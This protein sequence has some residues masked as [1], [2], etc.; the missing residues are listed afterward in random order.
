[1]TTFGKSSCW[2]PSALK[3]R[4]EIRKKKK[5]KIKRKE[6]SETG[7]WVFVDAWVGAIIISQ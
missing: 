1:M 4:K 7:C 3:R 5:E 6:G 2:G